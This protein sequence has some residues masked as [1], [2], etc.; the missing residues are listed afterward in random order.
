M[1]VDTMQVFTVWRIEL[2]MR[3]GRDGRLRIEL[4]K[5]RHGRQS[6][7]GR[8]RGFDRLKDLGIQRLMADS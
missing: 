3:F 2:R 8:E 4:K 6:L 1:A 5:R 7:H